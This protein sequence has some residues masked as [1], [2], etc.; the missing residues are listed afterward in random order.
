MTRSGLHFRKITLAAKGM[1]AVRVKPRQGAEVEDS[2]SGP[3]IVGDI[4]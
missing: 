2:D 4:I 3:G 1:E